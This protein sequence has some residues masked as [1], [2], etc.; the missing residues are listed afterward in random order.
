MAQMHS[1]L[2]V[3]VRFEIR[4]RNVTGMPQP[5]SLRLPQV[6]AP[7]APKDAVS[8][9]YMMGRPGATQAVFAMATTIIP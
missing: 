1:S 8:Q 9:G 2:W 3:G 6:L 5:H 4:I 7:C